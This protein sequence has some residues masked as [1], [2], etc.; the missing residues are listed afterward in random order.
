MHHILAKVGTRRRGRRRSKR[1]NGVRRKR[2]QGLLL[3]SN[4]LFS[5]Q[6]TKSEHFLHPFLSTANRSRAKLKPAKFLA[7]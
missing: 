3:R 4:Q 5:K 7:K 1:R 2:P 6:T